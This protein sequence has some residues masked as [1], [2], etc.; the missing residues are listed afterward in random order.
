MKTVFLEAHHIKNL[1][2]GF[3]QFN[4]H[5]LKNIEKIPEK[6]V[7]LVLHAQNIVFLKKEFGSSFGYKKYYSLRRYPMFR[8]RRKYD[9]W[10]SMNQNTQ[11]EPYHQIPYL[12]TVHNIS[13]IK[14]PTHYRQLPNHVKFQEKL[15]RS[16]AITYISNFA[17]QSTHQFFDVPNVPEYVIYN[18]NPISEIEI[19]DNYS[20]LFEI[21]KPFLFTIGEITERKNFKSLVAM[22]P[23]LPDFNLVIAGKNSTAEAASLQ[24][25]I[26]KLGLGNRI[27]V[28]G[29]ISE[30]DKMYL[31]QNCE[32]FVFPSLREGFGLPVIEAMRFGKPVFISNNTSLPEIGGDIA[33]YWDH[34]DPE[35][36]ANSITEG[37][38][39]FAANQVENAAKLMERAGTF[40]WDA[41]AIEYYKVYQSLLK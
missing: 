30:T 9:L 8:I 36:M 39:K 22:L 15:N 7:Q 28:P 34:Y 11:I 38:H 13:H 6:D 40:S 23:F 4:F 41:A 24:A 29:K 1:Y 32:A 16:H 12:L 17:K 35:Y 2:F 19:P 33:N 26:S 5:L 20:P 27:L 18:G 25:L 31:Y 3:G 37:L 10:H 14:D 21:K